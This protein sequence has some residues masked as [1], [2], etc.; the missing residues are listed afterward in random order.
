MRREVTID[1]V[2][3]AA[4][5][6]GL[7]LEP[8]GPDV[9]PL[10]RNVHLV[11]TEPGGI[12]GNHLHTRGTE[13][14]VAL[15]PG[16]FRYRDGAEVRDLNIPEGLAYR[17]LIPPGVAHAFRNTGAGPMVLIGFN[18]EPYDPERPDVVPVLLI[19]P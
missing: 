3:V 15:G 5:A 17:F 14:T 1:P 13:V 11:L 2:A 16:L 4:D 7:V 18:T 9:L 19:E 12:R 6:R 8:I 10:Q